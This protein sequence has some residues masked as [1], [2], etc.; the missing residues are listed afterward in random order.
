MALSGTVWTPISRISEA[1]KHR[2]AKITKGSP[3][4]DIKPPELIPDEIG[5]PGDAGSVGDIQLVEHD[6]RIGGAGAPDAVDRLQPPRLV[7]RRQDDPEPPGREL[8]AG[9]QPDPFVAPGNQRDPDDTKATV[10][11]THS[12]AAETGKLQYLQLAVEGGRVVERSSAN[13]LLG[14]FEMAAASIV[15]VPPRFAA[16]GRGMWTPRPSRW[17]MSSSFRSALSPSF[18]WSR[19]GRVWRGR[20]HVAFGFGPSSL[21]RWALAQTGGG[22]VEDTDTAWI[23]CRAIN[24]LFPGPSL[25]VCVEVIWSYLVTNLAYIL[26]TSSINPPQ[27]FRFE[28]LSDKNRFSESWWPAH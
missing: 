19:A 1:L 27:N 2:R 5:Q 13:L 24:P 22:A 12:L 21:A 25:L 26:D 23:A 8:P 7:P 28:H 17:F 9:L 10:P 3:Y 11:R 16:A 4:Q 15:V 6:I 20:G 18:L 14:G